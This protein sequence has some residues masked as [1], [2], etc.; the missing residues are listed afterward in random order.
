VRQRLAEALGHLPSPKTVAA[1]RYLEKDNHFQVAEAARFSLE[2][3][4]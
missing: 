1:L 4:S 3:L 2:R